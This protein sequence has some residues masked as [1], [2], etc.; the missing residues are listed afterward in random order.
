MFLETPAGTFPLRQKKKK[1]IE[2]F[3]RLGLAAKGFVHCLLGGISL[4]AALGLSSATG[5]KEKAFGMIYRQPFGQLMLAVLG[6]SLLGFVMLRAFQSFDDSDN[7]GADLKGLLYRLGKA[8]GALLYLGVSFYA[9]QLAF[10]GDSENGETQEFIV[11]KALGYDLGPLGVGIAAA[12]FFGQGLI[13]IYA[14]LTGNFM[15][16]MELNGR[17]GSI[18]LRRMGVVGYTARGIVLCILGYFLLRAALHGDPGEAGDT[19]GAFAFLRQQFGNW[20]LAAVALGFFLY[21]VFLFA[22]ARHERI[23]ISNHAPPGGT[24]R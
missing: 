17:S 2:G 10:S 1:Y 14:G 15:K 7:K 5:D 3:A 18:A 19:G 9:L 20:L 6:F 21:G 4:M 22:R 23:N 13:Q 16:K 11:S 8:G 12:V 24:R